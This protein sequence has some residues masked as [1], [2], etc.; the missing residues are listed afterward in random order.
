M[1]EH[2]TTVSD[3]LVA[4][5]SSWMDTFADSRQLQRVDLAGLNVSQVRY[6][7]YLFAYDPVLETVDGLENWDVTNLRYA[8]N[9]FANDTNLIG[10][11]KGELNLSRWRTENL[12]DC[13]RMFFRSGVRRVN[14]SN[15]HLDN[16]HG[17]TYEM[18]AQLVHPATIIMNN[19]NAGN[20]LRAR[21]FAGDQPLVVISNMDHLL[22]LNQQDDGHPAN[23]VTFVRTS[24]HQQLGR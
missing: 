8:Y 19:F 4:T 17:F 20:E 7:S 3:Q 23:T 24:D 15:W 21:D 6:M 12:F 18:F 9:F 22:S 1:I 5:D 13:D 14:V 10:S 16:G 2:P 11:S